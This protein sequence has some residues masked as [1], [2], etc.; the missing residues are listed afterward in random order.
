MSTIIKSD[1]ETYQNRLAREIKEMEEAMPT[2]KY[3]V[4]D[5][6]KAFQTP[7]GMYD[8]Y[9]EVIHQAYSAVKKHL[10][11]TQKKTSG[12]W[13]YPKFM[14]DFG[15]KLWVYLQTIGNDAYYERIGEPN[16]QIRYSE[17]IKLGWKQSRQ[18]MLKDIKPYYEVQKET[19]N[20]A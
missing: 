5:V 14:C 17:M 15:G 2:I 20:I 9:E 11:S 8:C 3:I 13:V 12:V 10:Q 7:A 16:C 1:F 18:E 4:E 19:Q 6:R